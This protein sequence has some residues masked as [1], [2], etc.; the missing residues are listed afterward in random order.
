MPQYCSFVLPPL[1][2]ENRSNWWLRMM[3]DIINRKKWEMEIRNFEDGWPFWYFFQL[4]SVS[5]SVSEW[6]KK[7]LLERLSPLKTL[8]LVPFWCNKICL[9][10]LGENVCT[11]ITASISRLLVCRQKYKWVVAESH[12]NNTKQLK[13]KH[14][15]TLKKMSN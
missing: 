9:Y 13:N 12:K 2:T 8:L 7:W 5:E 3:L 15:G 4:L 1:K 14:I 11:E 10:I 6:V